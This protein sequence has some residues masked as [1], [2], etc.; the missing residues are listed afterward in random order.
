MR[1]EETGTWWQQV[2]GAA[3]FGPLKGATLEPVSSD[4]LTFGLWKSETPD[5]EVLAPVA[6]DAKYYESDWEP[7]VAKL[8]VVISFHGNGLADRDVVLGLEYNGVARA[9]PFNSLAAQSPIQDR[10]GGVPILL[11]VGPDGK[12]VR[13]FLRRI[14]S[15]DL[16]FFRKTEVTAWT[17]LDSASGSEWDFQGC[18]IHGPAQG[19]CL[20]RL[21]VLKDYWFDWRNYHPR[22]SV[23]NY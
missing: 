1:D 6:S 11:V 3:I 4:E 17:L 14:D 12:S 7:K 9:Y 23:Y 16:E 13:A 2:T 8:P 15:S 22:T 10:L 5:G 21:G 18:A 19:R 20:E